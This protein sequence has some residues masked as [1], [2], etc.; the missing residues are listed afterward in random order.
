MH[1]HQTNVNLRRDNPSNNIAMKR[2]PQLQNCIIQKR[3]LS[4][5]LMLLYC[6]VSQNRTPRPC[7]NFR[8]YNKYHLKRSTV[9]PKN[10]ATRTSLANP[11]WSRLWS[12]SLLRYGLIAL[13]VVAVM[14]SAISE[15][16]TWWFIKDFPA[17]FSRTPQWRHSTGGT[18]V[19]VIDLSK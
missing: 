4:F 12:M 14:R 5:A 8:G 9:L 2:L 19:R 11:S 3:L 10:L 16:F 1:I 18:S 17:F 7:H 15:F 6:Q 13:T